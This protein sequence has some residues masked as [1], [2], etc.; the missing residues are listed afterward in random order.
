[1]TWTARKNTPDPPIT[2]T[3]ALDTTFQPSATRYT[4]LMYTIQ[5]V[6]AAAQSGTVELR[7]DTASPPTTARASAMLAVTGAGDSD[8]TRSMVIGV[9]APGD[10]VR[11]V[12]AG[13]GT[14][15]IAHQTEIAIA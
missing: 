7:V 5:L 14:P 13:T 11:L 4:L 15:T 8:T 9:A 3:R 1:M 12:F 6:G 10:N 2:P